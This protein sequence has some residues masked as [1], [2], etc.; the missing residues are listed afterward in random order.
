M[1]SKLMMFLKEIGKLWFVFLV[2]II[3][4]IA[5]YKIEVALWIT[6]ISIII[7]TVSSI[8]MHF[9]N[10][11]IKK[12]M[13]K[14]YKIDDNMIAQE[15][16]KPIKKIKDVLFDLSQDQEKK[17]WLI[18]YLNKH[19]I[20]FNK[21]TIDRFMQLHEENHDMKR[22]LVNLKKYQITSLEELTAIKEALIRNNRLTEKE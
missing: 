5:I 7:I 19:Y 1:T 18:I 3:I 20:C 14:N 15:L 8:L 4:I 17:Q 9:S 12:I 16:G 2:I 11:K 22:I 6:V 21:E 10:R 13:K